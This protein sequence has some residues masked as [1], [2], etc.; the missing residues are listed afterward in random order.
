LADAATRP[1][2]VDLHCHVAGLGAGE[3]GSFVSLRMR[4]SFRFP[5]FLRAFG[6]SR[7]EI[8]RE[9]DGVIVRR[10]SERLARSREVDRAL[11]LPLDAVVDPDGRENREATD[12]FVPDDFVRREAGKYPNLL[13][14]ASIHPHR[15]DALERLEEAKARGAKLVKWLPPVQRMDPAERRHIPYYEKLGELGLPLL[16]HTGAEFAFPR[17]DPTLGDPL[18]LTLPVEVGI[19]VIAAHGGN[20]GRTDGEANAIRF[21]RL[22]DAHENLY[23]D[24]S[25]LTLVT[26]LGG[27]R[28]LLFPP[29]RRERL[30]FG[31]DFPLPATPACSPLAFAPTI[32]LAAALRARFTKNPWDRDVLLKRALG[33][34]DEVFR[35]GARLL[36]LL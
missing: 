21:L 11:L 8:E 6:V 22:Y 29:E 18:R 35:R 20:G 32:G 7:R 28:R 36:G 5:F 27:L 23:A 3:S 34:P 30:L 12:L 1:P 2:V 14:G 19:R 26:R 31:T 25:A 16:C 17:A 24:I 33:V 4:R 10:V 13:H 15:K 9:G